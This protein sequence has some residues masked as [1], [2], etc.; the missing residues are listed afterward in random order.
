MDQI[1]A[2]I[3]VGPDSSPTTTAAGGTDPTGMHSCFKKEISILGKR[4]RGQAVFKFHNRTKSGTCLANKT[5]LES[6]KLLK[7]IRQE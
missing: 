3:Q 1:Q 6:I 4:E 5:R 7:D 2:N